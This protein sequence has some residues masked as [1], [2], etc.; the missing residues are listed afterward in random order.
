MRRWLRLAARVAV[1]TTSLLAGFGAESARADE[2]RDRDARALDLFEKSEAAYDG[3][4][5]ADAIALLKQSYELKKEGVL[6]YNMGRA[7]EGLGDLA[8]AAQSYEA[9][10]Q[11]TPNAQDRGALERRIATLRRQLAEREALRKQAL[12]HP[13]RSPS[14]IPWVIAGVGAA[15]LVT[16]GVVGVLAS[17]RNHDAKSE[18]TYTRADTLQSQAESFAKV[19]NICFIAG[20]VVLAAGVIWG[21]IDVSSAKSRPRT[22]GL[23]E[24]GTFTF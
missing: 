1:L 19:A 13:P 21:I 3:G 7:Y 16:G 2:T 4:R 15:G 6:L 10:L 11:A 8:N 20:G 17:Q 18:P 9:F 12:Q 24:L 23:T 5:F 22:N 14:A